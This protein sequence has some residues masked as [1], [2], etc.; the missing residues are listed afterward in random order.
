MS[1]RVSERVSGRVCTAIMHPPGLTEELTA[2][3][4]G[5][6]LSDRAPWLGGGD[7]GRWLG[8]VE[9]PDGCQA[10]AVLLQGRGRR[11]TSLLE[12]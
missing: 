4:G 9:G 7:E 8:H 5:V 6:Y 2:S 10:T 3:I 11:V 12:R 1:E